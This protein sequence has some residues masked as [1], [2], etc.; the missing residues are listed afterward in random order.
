[1]SDKATEQ[2][3][4]SLTGIIRSFLNNKIIA[5]ASTLIMALPACHV[6]TAPYVEFHVDTPQERHVPAY[7]AVQWDQGERYEGVQ[8][9]CHTFAATAQDSRD[10][11]GARIEVCTCYNPRLP[12][13]HRHYRC[14]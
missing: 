13:H 3:R 11:E 8:R 7:E 1:M 6:Q 12:R 9:E 14:D 5:A 10:P 4:R 2:K